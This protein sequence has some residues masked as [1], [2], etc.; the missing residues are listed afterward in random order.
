MIRKFLKDSNLKKV[1]FGSRKLS[2]YD[3]F[4]H[5]MDIFFFVLVISFFINDLYC[6]IFC[7]ID[8][9]F[10]IYDINDLISYMNNNTNNSIN[11]ASNA[12]SN[13]N[14]THT[15]ILHD[16]SSWSNAIVSLFLYG[17]GAYRLLLQRGGTPGSRFTIAT[18]TIAAYFATRFITNAINEHDYVQKHFSSWG[19]EY[20][21]SGEASIIFPRYRKMVEAIIEVA[22][23][24]GE[25]QAQ[26]SCTTSSS[27]SGSGSGN[28]SN[29]FIPSGNDL[30]NIGN[31][32]INTFMGYIRPILEPVQ[33]SYSN[34]ML[35]EQI[36][37]ISI[38]LFILSILIII[39]FIFFILNI[40][41]FIYSDRIINY[42]SNKYIIWYIKIN[43][44]FIGLELFLLSITLLN[45]M[46]FLSYGIHFI[47]THPITFS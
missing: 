22:R 19:L 40:L 47:A 25:N 16:D 11:A 44:K 1:T 7:V 46:Y 14:T 26:A 43:K 2:I 29:N 21:N 8:K 37:G 4:I 45:S 18:T 10:H 24:T 3:R 41:A 13:S 23:S 9:I 30:E 33:V 5:Y 6:G 28:I 20:N 35:A 27:N 39:L 34:E 31:K 42:F 15:H 12:A 17:T 38:F 36:Y 32:V